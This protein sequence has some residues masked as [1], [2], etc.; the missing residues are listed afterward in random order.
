MSAYGS[1][2]EVSVLVW[3]EAVKVSVYQKSKSVWVASGDYM[4]ESITVQNGSSRSA[5]TLWRST[6]EYRGN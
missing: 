6:A 2:R 3:G 5:V 1:E 4:G